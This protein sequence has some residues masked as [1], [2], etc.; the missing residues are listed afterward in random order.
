MKKL[1]QLSILFALFLFTNKANAQITI[2]YTNMPASGDT[3]RYST[4]KATTVNYTVTG[5]NVFWNYDTLVPTGQ[6]LYDYTPASATPYF[7][8]FTGGDYGLEIADSIGFATYEFHNVYDFYK[9]TASSF[10]TKGMG[11]TYSG[12]PLA[13]TYNPVDQIYVFPLNYLNHDS[14]QYKVT[15]ALTSTVSYS[16]YG[17][18]ITDVDGWGVIKTPY[19]S[20][21]CIRVVSTTYGKDSIHYSTFGFATP[22]VQRSYK[23]LSLTEKIPV[24]ELDGTY[25]SGNFTPT[26]AKYRD[27]YRYF[28]G[29]NQVANINNQVSIYPNPTS[30][31]LYVYTKNPDV[32]I[33]NVF[34][35][36]GVL[37]ATYKTSGMITKVSMQGISNGCYYY[38]VSTKD[39]SQTATGKVIV[40][41]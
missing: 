12:L 4:C 30:G 28:A 20:V 21:P 27:T 7:F 32:S 40:I 6:G 14:T 41:N 23:W 22:D 10:E 35:M 8:Y 3:I 13:A 15:V 37:V 39:G 1:V 31:D 9:N 38:N 29:I 24:L 2:T 16:Q 34:N 11:F 26:S 36:S 17:Y 25:N 19:D 18:R 33:I 5:A